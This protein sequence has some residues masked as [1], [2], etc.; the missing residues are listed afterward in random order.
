MAVVPRGDGGGVLL[1]GFPDR[2][3]LARP[4]IGYAARTGTRKNLDALR[5]RGWRLLVSAKGVQRTEG[6][7][8]AI[9]NGA[10]WAFQTGNAFD[11]DAF[12]R[13]CDAFAGGADWIVI[14][15]IVAG[16]ARS[17]EFSLSWRAE[18]RGYGRPLLLAVQNGMEV[19]HVRPHVGGEV[20]IFVGGDTEWKIA[21]MR[22][23]GR[24]AAEVDC[25]LHVGRVNTV[26]RVVMCA[27]AGA[28]SFDGSGPSKYSRDVPKL[29][30]AIQQPDMFSE[31]SKLR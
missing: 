18:L 28:H 15:D 21:T 16:G 9:D 7:P 30:N 2:V 24:L 20:G 17:L 13:C 25:Y 23:W 19:E 10:W 31:R 3:G 29:S 4:M 5:A 8:Y 6:F 27:A 14:P 11:G 22:V 12:R 26:R 1:R